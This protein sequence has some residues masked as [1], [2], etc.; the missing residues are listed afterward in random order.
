MAFRSYRDNE[1]PWF[2]SG[3]PYTPA[4]LSF[5][6]NEQ[7]TYSCVPSI[8]Q[9]PPQHQDDQRIAQDVSQYNTKS[10]RPIAAALDH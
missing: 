3:P 2:S 5:R 1:N 6:R 10:S 7:P 8:S 9:P 4:M